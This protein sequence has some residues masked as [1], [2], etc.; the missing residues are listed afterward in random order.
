[1]N[2]NKSPGGAL[3]T[4]WVQGRA[5]GKGIYFPDIGIKNGINFH[6]FGIRNGTYFQDLYM[7]YISSDILFRK[8]GIRS[9]ILFQKIGKRN[10]YFFE[11]SMARPRPKSGQVHPP[12]P[13]PPDAKDGQS[14]KKCSVSSTPS[15]V[16]QNSKWQQNNHEKAYCYD[17]YF[18]ISMLRCIGT[19][20]PT[21]R[22]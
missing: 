9:G 1:M 19:D 13:P 18:V 17:Y 4:F 8:I 5:I 12:P 7:K 15:F 16:V 21:T 10:G 2:C 6:N 3:D 20:Y 22:R 14:N 11:A